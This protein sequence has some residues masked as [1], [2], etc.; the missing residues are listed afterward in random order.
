MILK[1][2]IHI[3]IIKLNVSSW[4]IFFSFKK[5]YTLSDERK[6]ITSKY[7]YILKITFSKCFH[8]IG[9]WRNY[10]ISRQIFNGTIIAKN[11]NEEKEII[12]NNMVKKNI[13]HIP[14]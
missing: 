9:I 7:Y 8:L 1:L 14:Q 12:S 3:L 10:I 6:V 2:Y 4:Y 13:I 5:I 11:L